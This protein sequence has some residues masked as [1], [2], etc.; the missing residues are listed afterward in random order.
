MMRK[1]ASRWGC[2]IVALLALSAADAQALLPENQ[3][4]L[5]LAHGDLMRDTARITFEWPHPVKFSAKAEGKTVTITFERRADPDFGALLAQ[6]YPYIT[7][8]KRSGDG[9]TIVLSMDKAY[10]VR[11]F[12]SDNVSGIDILGVDPKAHL[13]SAAASV[14]ALAP[15]AGDPQSV[16]KPAEAG[17]VETKPAE[18]KPTE[19]APAAAQA[20]PEAAA[21]PAA[22]G[23][24]VTP[25][26]ATA[27]APSDAK[28]AEAPAAAAAAPAPPPGGDAEALAQTAAK[29][30]VSNAVKVGISASEDNAVLR[31]PFTQRVAMA[32]F[33]R[34]GTAWIVFNKPLTFDLS[35]FDS[36]PK[37]VIGK[38]ELKTQGNNVILR[39]PTD[40]TVYASVAREEG[41]FEWAVLMTPKRRNLANAL[42][43]DVNTDP[44]S[45][46]HVFI[47]ALEMADSLTVQD[48][49][50]GDEMVI[51]PL[52]NVGEGV[53]NLRQF[54]EFTLLETAQGM[55]VAKKADDVTVTQ[56]R[57]G[58][59]ISM[60]QG[61]TLTP[62]LP[63]VERQKPVESLQSTATFFPYDEWKL[64]EKLNRRM[65]IRNLFH[66]VVESSNVQEA[67][68]A[69]LKLAHIY[70]SEGMGAET[71]AMLDGINRTN[72]AYYRSAKLNALRGAASFMM[73][74][75]V[76][77]AHSFAAP[78]LNNNKEADYWRSMLADL[79]GNPGQNY[80]YLDLNA[81]YISKYPPLFRQRLAIVSADRAID[82]KEYNTALKI[83]DTLQQ[84][85]LLDGI[86]TYVNFLMAKISSD[87]GQ[88]EDAVAMWDK[89]A[90]DSEHLFVQA[91][92]EFSRIVWNMEH[93]ELTKDEMI[94][95]LERL[96]L[97][98]HGDSLELKV[99]GLLGDLYAEKKDFIDAMRIWDGG[100]MSFPNTAASVEM[101]HKMESAFI[102]MFN[103]GGADGLPTIDALAIYYQYRNYAPPGSTGKAMIQSLADRLIDIDLLDQAASLLDHQMRTQ[104]EKEERSQIG[105]KLA[106]IHLLNH[107]PKKALQ[108]LQDSVYGE[109][110][111]LLRMQRNRLTAQALVDL[112]QSDKA[113]Q[114]LGQD[115]NPDAERVRQRI[116]WT[117]RDWP[118]LTA[119]VESTLKLR[120]DAA[121]PLTL[122]ESE[123]VLE[124]GLSYVF[125]NNTMQ[126][127]YLRDYFGPL[128]QNNP[129]K[130][131]FDFITA[132]DILPT[133][134]NFEEVL[135]YL[136]DTR[137][138]IN[139]YQAHIK[140]AE[141]ETA[142]NAPAATPA[143][144]PAP[145]APAPAVNP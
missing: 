91:R 109:N 103:E 25:A 32:V 122:D 8:A 36:L 98:W 9:K 65:E 4:P 64:D 46:P 142:S 144:L 75:F 41:S 39:V 79:L 63:Q 127:Q 5:P 20:Q 17:P 44:P 130:P 138:F 126:L 73:Y 128:M 72:S 42:R 104:A 93:N 100:V 10:R 88:E 123:Q 11:T 37:T 56:V 115:D 6:L 141:M 87:T 111:V 82:G 49:L 106:S 95:K 27:T 52:F 119:S 70:L 62:G 85:K 3:A 120:R 71:I 118:R 105:A 84:A 83:F 43:V 21:P 134:T 135:K 40:G 89:L 30:T 116:Y 2:G 38:A 107:Q 28:P 97:A 1:R 35:D 48:P 50:I 12:I 92:A 129:Y 68:Q 31:F 22:A 53:G 33:I 140:T 57:D 66:K 125:Q 45:P 55:V 102:S 117:E 77:A 110:P 69:R 74:R 16:A 18:A 80:D 61:A 60:P 94:D 108:V 137:E 29:Q 113:L 133:P 131:M 34:S 47:P 26:P 114:I 13:A 51:T 101:S 67:N 145:D 90:E 136:S 19:V 139:N 124:L 58:L 59:R 81:D 121:A 7:R 54:I 99:L 15:A 76:E 14:A 96:R 23:P 78:E 24:D 132:G 112:G 143:A 86:D